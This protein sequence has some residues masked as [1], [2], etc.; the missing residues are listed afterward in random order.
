MIVY[1]YLTARSYWRNK[2]IS[3]QYGFVATG[4][5]KER[6]FNPA[7]GGGALLDIGI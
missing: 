5:R 4:A 3:C 6:K 2:H 1:T 7:L